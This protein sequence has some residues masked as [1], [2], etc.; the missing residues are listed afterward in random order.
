MK[1]LLIAL[2]LMFAVVACNKTT[3]EPKAEFKQQREEANEDYRQ[4]MK[5]VH[6][7]AKKDTIDATTERDEEIEKAHEDLQEVRTD[8]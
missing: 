8:E 7:D 2:P 5:D 6:E 3:K 1:L 4:E